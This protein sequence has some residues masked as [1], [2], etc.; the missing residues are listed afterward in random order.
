MTNDISV[1]GI[2]DGARLAEWLRQA[3]LRF[4]WSVIWLAS[5]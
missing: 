5:S 1:P 2:E 3:G 4:G